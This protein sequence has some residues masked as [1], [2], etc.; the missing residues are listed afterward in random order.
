M[1][2]HAVSALLFVLSLGS[3]PPPAAP[4]PP[5]DRPPPRQA[6]PGQVAFDRMDLNQDGVISREEFTQARGRAIGHRGPPPLLD[7][8]SRPRR[9]RAGAIGAG[10]LPRLGDRRPDSSRIDAPP[11]GP[12][13]RWQ[14]RRADPPFRGRGFGRAGIGGMRMRGWGFRGRLEAFVREVVREELARGPARDRNDRV[15]PRPRPEAAAPPAAAPSTPRPRPGAG[16]S[17]DQ[18]LP[19]PRMERPADRATGRTPRRLAEPAPA[20]RP[21]RPGHV[22]ER[23]DRN[24]DGVI[25]RD[26]FPGADQRFNRLDTDR[27]GTLSRKEFDQAPVG[28]G[29]RARQDSNLQPPGSKPGTLSN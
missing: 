25:S 14:G 7:E 9:D 15:A 8:A 3:F 5:E 27:N 6:V 1:T 23:L 17:L 24:N 16:R 13:A 29:A 10:R 12:G 22:W 18:A 4:A 28:P 20:Q 26:E 21:D 19:P 2:G 11:P